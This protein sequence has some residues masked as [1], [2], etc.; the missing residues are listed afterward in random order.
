MSSYFNVPG[1][2]LRSLSSVIVAKQQLTLF[3]VQPE[4][5]EAI[6]T[7]NVALVP[8]NHIIDELYE[9]Q[10][11]N[12]KLPFAKRRAFTEVCTWHGTRIYF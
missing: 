9:F 6:L 12:A 11:Q 7:R 1:N 4:L 5:K 10:E 3:T 8:P 2:F